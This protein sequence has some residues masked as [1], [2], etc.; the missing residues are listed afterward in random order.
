MTDEIALRAAIDLLRN[1]V[2]NGRMPSGEPLDHDAA[3]LHE[4]AAEHLEHLLHHPAETE[5]ALRALIDTMPI[6]VWTSRADGSDVFFNRRRLEYTGAGVDWYAIVHPDERVEHDAAWDTAIRT[7][8]PF[9]F[10]QRLVAGDGSSRWFLGRAEPLRDAAGNVTRWVG[11]NL[12]IEERKQAEERLRRAERAGRIAFD[13]IPVLAWRAR[14]DGSAEF[15]NKR[16]LDY[17]GLELRDALDWGW[18]VAIHP[19]DV[20]SLLDTWRRLLTDAQA[21]EAE[22]RLRRFDGVYRWFLFRANPLLDASGNVEC[23]YGTNIDIEDRKQA[24]QVRADAEQQLKTVIDSI[25][26]HVW[27]TGP[28]GEND[29]VNQARIAFGGDNL[30]WQDFVHPDD[31]VVHRQLWV[32][33][34]NTGEPFEQEMRLRRRDGAYRWFL[35]RVAPQRDDDG[36]IARWFG[37]NTDIDD[38][39]QAQERVRRSAQD[40]RDAIDTIPTHVWS[41]L[42]DGRDIYLNRRRLE[43]AGPGVDW[44]TIVHPDE[45][46]EHN[47]TWAASMQT[48]EPWEVECRLLRA[49]GTYRWFLVRAEPLRD[50][51][52]RIV[53]WFGTNT[54]INDLRMAQQ[55]LRQAERELRATIDTIPAHIW[56]C[57]PDGTSDYFNRRRIEYTGPAIEFFDIVHPD[58]RADHD[59]KWDRSVRTGQP[60]E[61]ENRL[62]RFDGSYRRF[63]GRAEPLRD[64]QGNIIRWFGTNTDI[65]D[66]R[67]TEEAL[68]NSQA[69]LAH[70]SRISTLG[71]LTASIT[72]EVNQPL[73]GIVTNAEASLRWLRRERPNLEEAEQAVQRII[74][75]GQRAAEVVHRL[76]ALARKEEPVRRPLHLNELVEESLPLV[77]QEVGRQGIKVELSLAPRMPI[78]LADRVQLQQVLINLFINAIQAM[79]ETTG[80][81]RVLAISSQVT[82]AG[83]VMLVVGDTGA[84]IDPGAA[85]ELFKAFVTTKANGMGMGLSICKSIIE[86][87][88]GRIWADGG[89]TRGAVFRFVLPVQ[90]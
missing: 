88:E 90:P 31:A 83:D 24:E 42:P 82:E 62:R 54:D 47:R 52:G 78:V 27:R 65:E 46:G 36:S 35:V 9:Q 15:V 3:A 68:Q 74:G 71:E 63:L 57:L 73:A 44:E 58:D 34:R 38:L 49:D 69:E 13:A 37:T 72:H 41:T 29:F 17:V 19:D 85:G 87:H 25:P 40:F 50:A 28:E 8:Q 2:E 89:E 30:E 76:R 39:K 64:E 1:S 23:W 43:Y 51:D 12:D 59:E 77:A 5:T 84:G 61:V 48:G 21:G 60:F 20:A 18:C 55:Q 6:H 16:F 75:E 7:G 45:R 22:V 32:E 4:Q 80:R 14:P 10:E 11:I 53:R 33:A 66:L 79:V 70:V 81:E 26:A 86:A 67:R 56:S